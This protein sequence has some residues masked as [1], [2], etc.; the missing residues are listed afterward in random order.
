M[1]IFLQPNLKIV[2]SQAVAFTLLLTLHPRLFASS[3]QDSYTYENVI[4]SSKKLVK[5]NPKIVSLKSI[6]YSG[7][8]L[9]IETLVIK[10]NK[11][12]K[13]PAI[14]INGAHHGNEKITAKCVLD[15]ATHL[16]ENY[17]TS[18]STSRLKDF[19]FYLLP[20]VNPD[21]FNQKSR[22]DSSG[23]DPNRDYPNKKIGHQGFRIPET[24]AVGNL[25]KSTP[26]VAAAALHSGFKGVLW[27]WGYSRQRPAEAFLFQDIAQA[28]AEAMEHN[29]FKQSHFDYPTKGE[30]IDY[31]YAEHQILAFTIEI[32]EAVS[33]HP[34]RWQKVSDLAV[35]GLNAMSDR[36]AKRPNL[37]ARPLQ[38]LL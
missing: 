14:F 34:H 30:F 38:G 15:F 32:D 31:A 19:D 2:L 35:R 11:N 3:N 8:G 26:V 33:V 21:G 28:I 24:R 36:L 18:P 25:L 1:A 4:T 9:P 37:A 16:V 6:G 5:A 12:K 13:K 29:V 27:P 10:V 17:R 22:F 20:V 7:D 23:I